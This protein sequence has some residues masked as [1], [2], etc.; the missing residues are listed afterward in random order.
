MG[1]QGKEDNSMKEK[2][3]GKEGNIIKGKARKGG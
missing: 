2:N 3:Q 1:R